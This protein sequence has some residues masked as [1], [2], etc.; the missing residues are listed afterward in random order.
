MLFR[1]EYET[2]EDV[3]FKETKHV[4]EGKIRTLIDQH[5]WELQELRSKLSPQKEAPF[6]NPAATQPRI[7]TRGG[8]WGGG[9]MD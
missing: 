1:S 9:H 3:S 4:L 8:T 6:N 2:E 7:S 5:R